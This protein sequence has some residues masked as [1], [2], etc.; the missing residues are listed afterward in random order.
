[1]PFTKEQR[2]AL[3]T[4]LNDPQLV[5]R[6]LAATTTQQPFTAQKSAR[7][8]PRPNRT[9]ERLKMAGAALHTKKKPTGN[10]AY[11]PKL[12]GFTNATK[13]TTWPEFFGFG[14]ED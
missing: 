8:Q 3:D 11:S 7:Q 2:D 4:V 5:S 14:K 13:E 12:F 1:M 9:Y 6:V 10:Q